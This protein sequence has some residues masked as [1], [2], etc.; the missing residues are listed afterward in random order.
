MRYSTF[1][2]ILISFILL[3]SLPG[4]KAEDGRTGTRS[5]PSDPTITITV[6]DNLKSVDVRPGSSGEVNF[7]MVVTCFLPSNAFANTSVEIDLT[8]R[9]WWWEV[10]EVAPLHFS[11]ETFRRDTPITIRA[12]INSSADTV[13]DL[14]I[15]GT[16]RYEDTN[17]SGVIEKRN[18]ARITVQPFFDMFI[19][20]NGPK[21]YADVGDWVEFRF[22]VTNRSNLDVNMTFN[23][24]K[25]SSHIELVFDDRSVMFKKGETKTLSIRV[26]QEPSGSRGNTIH[27]HA[28][29]DEDPLSNEWDLPLL[30]YTEPTISTFFYERN[31]IRL[32]IIVMVIASM[33]LGFFL[34]ERYRKG[35]EDPKEEVEP[36]KAVV[37][38]KGLDFPR[39]R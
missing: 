21:L 8:L 16:W 28:T 15:W 4:I 26:R 17:R 3:V 27:V 33:S 13:V 9:A 2:L 36:K 38:K 11:H 37:N 34:W 12:P 31:F 6:I 10:S 18:A 29:I 32:V 19:G 20:T 1:A 35:D 30:F 25:D 14:E 22:N 5:D 23:I 39:K 7:T 24:R